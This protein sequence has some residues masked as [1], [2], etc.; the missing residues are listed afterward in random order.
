MVSLNPVL[1][2]AEPV[3][4]SG[5]FYSGA[6]YELQYGYKKHLGGI[7]YVRSYTSQNK[8][9][10]GVK[11]TRD[12]LHR[13]LNVSYTY[14]FYQYKNWQLYAGAAFYYQQSDS[15]N[16]LYTS[17]ENQTER[18]L[19]T[20]TG[21]ALLFRSSYKL[22]RFFSIVLE[23]PIYHARYRYTYDRVYPLT[24]SMNKHRNVPDIKTK[25]LIPSAIY[26]RISI[27]YFYHFAAFYRQLLL[28]TLMTII[29]YGFF[30]YKFV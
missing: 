16:I 20:E 27:W 13:R 24:P 15:M 28:N 14:N 29:Y 8:F 22:N 10:N 17:I 30:Y 2:L 6:Y 25:F 26:F 9:V 11:N 3:K 18:G 4:N 5:L 21:G 7:G 1:Q 23:L 12:Q 19:E